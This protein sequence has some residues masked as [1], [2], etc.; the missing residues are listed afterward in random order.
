MAA[1]CLQEAFGALP[2][3][4]RGLDPYPHCRQRGDREAVHTAPELSTT[5]MT[6]EGCTEE[7]VHPRRGPAA[8]LYRILCKRLMA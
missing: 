1:V 7:N 6:Q 4:V 2:L 5:T 3:V 8:S